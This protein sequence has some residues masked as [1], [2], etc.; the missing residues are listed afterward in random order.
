L[1]A[2]VSSALLAGSLLLPGALCAQE[3]LVGRAL[4]EGSP[5]AGVE[6]SL[7]RVTR[8]T[9]GV[10][11][12]L[13]TDPEGRFG[14]ALPPRDPESFQVYFTTIDHLGVRHFGPAVHPGEVPARYVVELHDTV[15]VTAG[16]SPA[17]VVQRDI[18]V[19]QAERGGWE[20]NEI[21]RLEN[22][23]TR[24]LVGEGGVAVA[25]FRVPDG[26]EDLSVGDP[27][28]EAGDLIRMGERV[29]LVSPL[30]PGTR[31]VFVR[32][33]LPPV[34]NTATLLGD[35][36]VGL[37]NIFVRQPSPELTVRGLEPQGIMQAEGERFLR[38]SG[39]AGAPVVLSWTR[40]A[41]PIASPTTIAVS[42]L[43]LLLAGG[44]FL[45]LR[46]PAPPTG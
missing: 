7:H 19:M 45:A 40:A 33:R 34:P 29:L 24:T 46:R 31:E 17:R 23:G 38:F 25:E 14:F 27:D 22:P 21:V 43:A 20:V 35:G 1:K 18:I 41:A 26:V 15:H 2:L 9:A 39:E 44:L 42:A 4:L 10:V 11:E 30:L 6:V 32:Y 3:R 8:D 28:D 37:V 12:L 16:A 36:G 5:V 13:R